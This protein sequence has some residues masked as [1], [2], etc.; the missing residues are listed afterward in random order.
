[1]LVFQFFQRDGNG[2]VGV[3]GAKFWQSSVHQNGFIYLEV[4]KPGVEI[5]RQENRV[6]G[7]FLTSKAE[8]FWNL[9]V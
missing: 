1:M 9:G 8:L 3:N 6:C 4:I 2:N 7:S 5:F